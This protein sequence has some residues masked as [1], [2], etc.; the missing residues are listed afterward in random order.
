M[1]TC[2][3]CKNWQK[4]NEYTGQCGSQALKMLGAYYEDE[5]DEIKSKGFGVVSTAECEWD[6]VTL[7]LTHKSFG[8]V[9]YQ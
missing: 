5:L 2:K 8:C 9:N 7:L 3:D 4:L 1:M 6:D